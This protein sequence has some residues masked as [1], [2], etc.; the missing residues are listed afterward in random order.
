MVRIVIH[1]DSLELRVLS[2]EFRV[3]SI[4][5]G[6]CGKTNAKP[7]TQNLKLFLQRIPNFH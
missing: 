2:F 4:E 7:K 5:L 6:V 1:E 3:S